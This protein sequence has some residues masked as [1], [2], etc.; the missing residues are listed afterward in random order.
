MRIK[1]DHQIVA[2]GSDLMGLFDTDGVLITQGART[3]TGWKV[4]AEGAADVDTETRSDAI[5][6]MIEMALEVLPGDG[7]SCLVPHGLRDQP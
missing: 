3:A 5:T 6:A 7:Y 4:T 1:T 2:F